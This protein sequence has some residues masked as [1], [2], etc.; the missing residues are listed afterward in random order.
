MWSGRI[1]RGLGSLVALALLALAMLALRR[2]LHGYR[3]GEL[4]H[5][6]R[7]IPSTWL[8]IAVL[9]TAIN[10]LLLA[11]YDALGFVYIR[12]PVP[13]QR[14]ALTSFLGYA[15]SHNLGFGALT[16][17][18]VRFRLYSG[19]GL[20]AVEIAEVAAFGALTFWLGF[21]TLA[22]TA[23]VI[24]PPLLPA[25]LHVPF[26]SVRVLG[27]LML[28]AVAVYL[29]ASG[30]RRRPIRVRDW[31]FAAPPPRL[32]LAGVAVA[33][34][35]WAL[36]AAVFYVLM[37]TGGGPP[38]LSLLGIFL[39]AQIIGLI[40]HVPG[41]LGVFEALILLFLQ[42]YLSPV[43]TKAT[44]AGTLLVYRA[45]YYLIPFG[46]ALLVLAIDEI[47][48]RRVAFQRV[49]GYLEAWLSPVV[50]QLLAFTTFIGGAILLF[51]GATPAMPDRWKF[52]R[53]TLPLPVLNISHFM[54]SV[55][56][57]G[58]LFLA[59]G[60]QRRLDIAYPLTIALLLAGIIASLLKGLDY[61]EAIAL[62]I[63]LVVF[64]PCRRHFYRKASFTGERFSPRWAAA[65]A[66]VI[67]ASAWLGF[68]AHKHP[69][70]A[71]LPWWRMGSGAPRFLRAEVGIVV[72]ALVFGLAHLTRTASPKG[73]RPEPEALEQ[74]K[75]IIAQ[76]PATLANSVLMGDKML[77]FNEES[78]AFIMYAVQGRSWIALG[79]PVGPPAEHEELVW[80]YRELCD[81]HAG[82][83]VFHQVPPQSLHLYI[84]VGL[85]LL[86]IG[87][88]ARVPLESWSLEG[89]RRKE[90][91][92]VRRRFEKE[93]APFEIVPA[94][95]VPALLPELRRVSDAWLTEKD[96]REKRF[97]I[98][99]FDEAYL[100]HFPLAL[101]RR[102]GRIL[103]FANLW[104]G[105]PQEE[106]SV[107]L[108]RYLPETPHG[109]MDY[110]FG[111][112][113]LW[114]KQEG[115]RWFNLGVAPLAGL[116]NRRVAPLWNR[117]GNLIFR[118]G[119][120]FYGFQGLRE[121]KAKF[122]PVWEPRY[123]VHP[124]RLLLPNILK[125][126]AALISGGAK[127]GGAK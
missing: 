68:F 10:Y 35:D 75:S 85:S 18:A 62:W 88:E 116:E 64:I 3:Y 82:W 9:L 24:S 39:L 47:L 30:L 11:A 93:R 7:A 99:Y 15:F 23:F 60:I 37:P 80:Q 36:A 89:P 5:Q 117:I 31:E 72:V 94:E 119:G 67:V 118:H 73:R 100:R 105:F 14:V 74:A 87:E 8:W 70:Y 2:E 57:A 95:G 104:S 16:G 65:I 91:R 120:A 78:T 12:R 108:M 124:G 76:S 46:V 32:S 77:L 122:D 43:F 110:L 44:I 123:L 61:E 54:G 21:L 51:S 102:Q 103:A 106:L 126:L 56:G 20:G 53:E 55:A 25:G 96:G 42:P 33:C 101:V 71:T 111:E 115:Y 27:I 98:G 29:A 109:V 34:L 22:G 92:Q 6:A 40:S 48:R 26:E 66:I 50:P 90:F 69:Q 17:T 28:C 127:F 63:M 114:G 112:L 81:R 1:R 41:G 4:L 83:T 38:F 79:D 52:L 45:I 113:M 107:D 97:S 49:G 125:D 86:K 59:R 19:Y 58:L 121:Y 13:L 84:E